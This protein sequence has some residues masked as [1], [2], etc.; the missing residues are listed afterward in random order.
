MNVSFVGNDHTTAVRSA[1][2]VI[3]DISVGCHFA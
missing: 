2:V 3:N 1:D